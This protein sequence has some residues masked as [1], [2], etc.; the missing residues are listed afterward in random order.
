MKWSDL[1]P[2][3]TAAELAAFLR[4]S[5]ETVARRAREGTYP[6]LP[7]LRQHRFFKEQMWQVL[8]CSWREHRDD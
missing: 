6:T 4:V 8:T 1:P 7:G 2:V 5:E 3:L